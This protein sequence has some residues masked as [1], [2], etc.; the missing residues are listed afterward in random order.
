MPKVLPGR[1]FP[2]FSSGDV[3]VV[4]RVDEEATLSLLESHTQC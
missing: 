3:G 2:S 1:Q 4:K